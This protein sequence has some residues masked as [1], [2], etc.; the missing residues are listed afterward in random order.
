MS[1]SESATRL[2]RPIVLSRLHRL[3]LDQTGRSSRFRLKKRDLKKLGVP[4]PK[5]TN[6]ALRLLGFEAFAVKEKGR[7]NP[8]ILGQ[9]EEQVEELKDTVFAEGVMWKDLLRHA[10][11]KIA[12]GMAELDWVASNAFTPVL[13]LERATAPSCG[14]VNLLRHINEIP[15]AKTEFFKK[16]TSIKGGARAEVATPDSDE[17]DDQTST[18][19]D[20]IGTCMKAAKK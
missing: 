10:K 2:K 6:A 7:K 4:E 17:L 5:R 18:L 9:T 20:T 1:E 12:D 3:W 11:D 13:E 16:F 19:L 8:V 14:A 15:A